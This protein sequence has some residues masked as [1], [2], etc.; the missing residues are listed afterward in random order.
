MELDMFGNEILPKKPNP[1]SKYQD[2]KQVF[3]YRKG[4]IDICRKCINFR[5]Y[6]YHNKFYHKCIL[7][8]ES[9][10]TATDIR[11]TYVCDNYKGE[12]TK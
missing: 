5:R 12:Q 4:G 8:G 1:R 7:L 2:Y 6:E 10:S 3:N 9:H 11:V